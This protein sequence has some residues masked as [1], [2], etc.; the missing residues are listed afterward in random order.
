MPRKEPGTKCSKNLC[1]SFSGRIGDTLDS[2]DQYFNIF[3][4]NIQYFYKVLFCIDFYTQS[5]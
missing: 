2:I 4:I 5:S 1:L 3:I